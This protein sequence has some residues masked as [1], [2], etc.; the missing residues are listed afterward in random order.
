MRIPL[1]PDDATLPVPDGSEV[2]LNYSVGETR[3][4]FTG[5]AKVFDVP[6]ESG[7]D[8]GAGRAE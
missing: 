7:N 2:I 5:K 3:H 6:E 1:L 8:V 4:V